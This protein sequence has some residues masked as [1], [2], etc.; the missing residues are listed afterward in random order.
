[1]Q[2]QVFCLTLSSAMSLNIL[3]I[4]RGFGNFGGMETYV[5]ETAVEMQRLGHKVSCL[6]GGT[7]KPNG[8]IPVFLTDLPRTRR[9]WQSRWIFRRE[10]SRVLAQLRD[11]Q[12]FD[13][14]H[15]HD[16]TLEH[17][18]CTQHGP[19]L[20]P[21]LRLKPWKWLDP[22]ARRNLALERDK[23]HAPGLQAVVG[24]SK[25]VCTIVQQAYPH[26]QHRP[27][28]AIPPAFSYAQSPTGN[29]SARVPGTLGFIGYDWE[30]KGLPRALRIFCNLRQRDT[31]W[32]FKVGGVER[33]ALP[34]RL[35]RNLPEGVEFF[36]RT[37][38][39]KFYDGI[40]VLI[41]PARDEPFGMVLPEALSSGVPVVASDHCGACGHI[42]HPALRVLS[43]ED[44]DGIWA[45]ACAAH[46]DL[47]VSAPPQRGWADVARE[48]E[49]LYLEIL[50]DKAKMV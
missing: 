30:R 37:D 42:D 36:G 8:D 26:L 20:A 18:V 39:K 33:A 40:S 2:G 9:S 6:C 45:E 16:N 49:A 4:V 1:M 7:E 14:I 46:A 13:I 5:Y 48:H 28:R 3:Y 34:W 11:K 25:R 15:T 22:S 23:F 47:P 44:P 21:S 31:Q 19:C 43:L 38:A 35:R 12:S 27:L 24:C 29:R 10:V 41:H 17:T 50:Q 32:T